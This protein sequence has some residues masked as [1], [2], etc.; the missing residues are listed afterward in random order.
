MYDHLDSSRSGPTT[1]CM[2][3]LMYCPPELSR[4]AELC[5]I[6]FPHTLL[7]TG[8][9]P[10]CIA[11]PICKSTTRCF[12]LPHVRPGWKFSW[13]T[14]LQV[15]IT[16]KKVRKMR[17]EGNKLITSRT[18]QVEALT[19]RGAGKNIKGSK[20][21]R[22]DRQNYALSSP[23]IQESVPSLLPSPLRQT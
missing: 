14:S 21:R 12:Q 9:L 10:R 18:V 5:D 13:F 11:S 1:G 2:V 3:C 22:T 23:R 4:G 19:G 16:R 7:M 17:R 20:D 8:C 15:G 6:S